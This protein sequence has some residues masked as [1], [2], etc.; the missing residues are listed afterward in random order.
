MIDRKTALICGALIALMFATALWRVTNPQEWPPHTAWTATLLPSVM[1]FVFPV[2]GALVTGLLWRAL[3]ARADD[4][5]FEPWSRWGKRFSIGCCAGFSLVQGLLVA[6]SL[7]LH[8]PSA[9]AGIPAVVMMILM[10]FM[11][12]QM[13]K[14]PWFERRFSLGGELGPIYGP[15]L[16]RIV[17]RAAAMFAMA[18]FAFS[19]AAPAPLA[20]R[21][22]PY[23]L[24]A[25]ALFLLGIIALRIH[26][27]RKWRLERAAHG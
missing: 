9:I 7:G 6:Q 25:G 8:V 18:V 16:I 12:N 11:I 21:S 1:L 26:L 23:V 24:A 19:L 13:P 3:P 22:V 17:S 14:L 5:K 4:P 10:L 2:A 20:Q 15:R 27:A